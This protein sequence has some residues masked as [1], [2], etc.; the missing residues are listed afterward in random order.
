MSSSPFDS[1]DVSDDVLT[2]RSFRSFRST[3]F[4]SLT[5]PQFITNNNNSKFNTNNKLMLCLM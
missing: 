3:R 4:S 5:R 2:D 1:L